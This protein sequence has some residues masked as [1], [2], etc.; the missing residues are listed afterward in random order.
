MSLLSVA[1][2]CTT[3]SVGIYYCRGHHCASPVLSPSCG[4]T[5]THDATATIYD[6]PKRSA[7][8]PK[9]GTKQ[10]VVNGMGTC[11]LPARAAQSDSAVTS[12]GTVSESAKPWT[13]GRPPHGPSEA[14]TVVAPL[15]T[16]VCITVCAAPGGTMPG[17]G[18]SGLSWKRLRSVTSG[19]GTIA[20]LLSHGNPHWTSR[21]EQG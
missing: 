13:L 17:C 15:R 10:V 5:G 19:S 12:S 8:M 16:L 4:G 21:G 11:P 3:P 9:R 2:H 18:G 7:T 6:T 20:G 14:S 1:G